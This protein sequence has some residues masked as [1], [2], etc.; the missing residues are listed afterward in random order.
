LG[1]TADAGAP[2]CDYDNADDK[3]FSEW[4][5]LLDFIVS[6]FLLYIYGEREK[7]DVNTKII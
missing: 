7:W 1:V 2:S 6:V 5:F 3:V 4:G